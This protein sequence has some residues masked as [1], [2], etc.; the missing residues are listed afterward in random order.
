MARDSIDLLCLTLSERES[1]WIAQ[2]VNTHMHLRAEA[3]SA[4]SQSLRLLSPFLCG[5]PAAQGCARTVVLSIIRCSIS[6]SL[7]K[8]RCIFSQ[9]PCSLHLAKRLY[10]LYHLPYSAGSILHGAP[11][12]LIHRTP[13]MNRLQ[14]RSDLT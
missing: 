4:S 8:Y 7:E 3:A 5:A 1:Q 11:D 13:S 9:T 2:S 12:L 10:T 14:S 6:G